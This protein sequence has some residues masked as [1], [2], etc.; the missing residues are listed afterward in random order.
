MD[1]KKDGGETFLRRI[2]WIQK[3]FKYVKKSPKFGFK[4]I[5]DKVRKRV[6]FPSEFKRY[7]G[8]NKQNKR[9]NL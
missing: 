1:A 7:V 6:I 5:H 3:N 9:E 4:Y 8:G 2:R